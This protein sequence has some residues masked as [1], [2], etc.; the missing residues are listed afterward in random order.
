MAIKDFKKDEDVEIYVM[1]VVELIENRE[2]AE[3]R[4]KLEG[5]LKY[6]SK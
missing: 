3:S 5:I 1:T 2:N 6:H 4:I